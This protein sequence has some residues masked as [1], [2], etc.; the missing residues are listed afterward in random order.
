MASIAVGTAIGSGSLV[1]RLSVASPA[2]RDAWREVAASDPDALVTQSPEWLDAVCAD[3]GYEDASRLYLTPEGKRLV[4]PMVRRRGLWPSPIAPLA[5][6]PHAW[7]M[8]GVLAD[9]PVEQ[10]DIAAIVADLRSGPAVRTR[11]PPQ[12]TPP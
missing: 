9:S 4:L 2:P 12:P 11:D 1:T 8:G 7:G 3:G 10:R 5:S 6:M